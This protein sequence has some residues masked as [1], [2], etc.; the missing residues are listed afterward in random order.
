MPIINHKPLGDFLSYLQS[1]FN[2]DI[3]VN[4]FVGFIP[5]DKELDLTLQ[6]FMA[7]INPFCMYVKSDKKLMQKCL[8]MK[9]KIFDRC[10]REGKPFYGVCHAGA[11]ELIYPILNNNQLLGIINVGIF[12]NSAR[13]STYRI[14]K[15]C[16]CSALITDKTE[17]LFKISIKE[18][19]APD[20]AKE[21]DTN[22]NFVCTYLSNC[23][24]K[25][26]VDYHAA[27]LL[28]RKYNSSEDFILSHCI[29]FVNKNYTTDIDVCTLKSLCHCSESYI[30]HIFKKRTGKS[31]RSYVN[32]LR[33]EKAKNLLSD[34]MES[35]SAISLSVGFF[36]PDYF[37]RVFS[38]ITGISPTKYRE[39]FKIISKT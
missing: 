11:G 8:A 29:Q 13:L 30:N 24:D 27:D 19:L 22:F 16:S 31:V 20:K 18:S 35:I 38:R 34:S 33:I 14:K 37:S 36:D 6:P 1:K 25:L 17:N 5:L 26:S 23:F 15:M 32:Y 12:C 39:R 28:R 7:H 9:R 10:I 3:C 21:L 2:V 4:D